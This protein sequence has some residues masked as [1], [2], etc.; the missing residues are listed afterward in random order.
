MPCGRESVRSGASRNFRFLTFIWL[1]MFVIFVITQK[2]TLKKAQF[3]SKAILAIEQGTS[4]TKAVL[5]NR[6]FEVIAISSQSVCPTFH[7]TDRYEQ[8]PEALWQA[9][10]L[11]CRQVLSKAGLT[12]PDLTGISLTNQR[13]TFVVWKRSTGQPIYPAIT[14][15]DRR[16]ETLCE[17]WRKEGREAL[18]QGKTGLIL[19]PYF[20]GTKLHWL[21][22]EVTRARELA[23]QDDLSFGTIDSFLLWRMTGG[24]VHAT[25]ATNAS[26]TLLFNIHEQRWDDELLGLM[27]IPHTILP[28]VMDS[29]AQFGHTDSEFLG[30]PIPISAVIGDQQSALLGQACLTPGAAKATYGSGCFALVN[31][32]DHP[33]ISQN[34]LLTTLAYRL[35]GQPCYAVEGSIFMAGAVVQWLRDDLNI[36]RDVE[37]VEAMVRGVPLEQSEVMVPAFTGIGAPYWDHQAKGAVFG[38]TRN[39][40]SNHLVAA[41]LR[42]I[43]FQTEDLLKAMRFDEVMID[44]LRVDGGMLTNQWFLQTLS[45]VTGTPVL[46][47]NDAHAAA[48]GSA[49]LAALQCGWLARLADFVDFWEAGKRY[50]PVISDAKRDHALRRWDEA[51]MRIQAPL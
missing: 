45:D 19:D 36:I 40:Q 22:N 41:A 2:T 27:Q 32:G 51:L 46:T 1:F 15:Q 33:V 34:R 25:D 11:A 14:W 23:E 37:D 26:R 29:S 13:E 7:A 35:N 16:T 30:A 38:L 20:S 5:Y 31:S 42:S 3:M 39:T 28:E 17:Q 6:R 47:C 4:L 12:A 18:I 10:C 9:V 50:E 44:Q 48:R 8:D 43:A 24:R 49:V 21:L